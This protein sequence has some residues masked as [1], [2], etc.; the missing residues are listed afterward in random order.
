MSIQCE[1]KSLFHFLGEQLPTNRK[2]VAQKQRKNKKNYKKFREKMNTSIYCTLPF[3]SS[4]DS[5]TLSSFPT[6]TI[7]ISKGMSHVCMCKCASSRPIKA[8]SENFKFKLL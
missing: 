3:G 7:R 6:A 4:S 1:E 8:Q 5:R 2:K